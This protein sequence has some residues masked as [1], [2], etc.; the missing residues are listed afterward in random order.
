MTGYGIAH[1]I[2]LLA[3][4]LTLVLFVIRGVWM[5]AD[6]A[7]L[8]R[9]WVRITPHIVD[10]VLLVSALY[11]AIAHWGW[12]MTPHGWITA[13]IVALLVYIGLG[14]IAIKRGPT[15]AVRGGAFAAALLVFAY[16]M[17]TAVTKTALPV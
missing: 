13:K 4:L 14:V 10:T 11:L 1:G 3:V 5:L 12:P 9:K 16:I 7:M 6:S 2:H 8:H 17:Q 15:K